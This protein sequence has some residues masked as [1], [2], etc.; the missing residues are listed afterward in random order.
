MY[1]TNGVRNKIASPN[2][3]KDI[4]LVITQQ[5]QVAIFLHERITLNNQIMK[6]RS[7]GT[8]ANCHIVMF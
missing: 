4:T 8:L 3:H 5:A 2:M 6:S 1:I 7:L